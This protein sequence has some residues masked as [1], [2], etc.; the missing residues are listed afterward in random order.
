MQ[1]VMDNLE[2]LRPVE[3]VPLGDSSKFEQEAQLAVRAGSAS[4][5]NVTK[6]KAFSFRRLLLFVGAL[7]RA[8][9]IRHNV[10]TCGR[11]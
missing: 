8:Q 2:S 3:V 6:R 10:V 11:A 7:V 5:P 9:S 1:P 4:I